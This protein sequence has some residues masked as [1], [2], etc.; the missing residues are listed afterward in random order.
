[1]EGYTTS[2]LKI[3]AICTVAVILIINGVTGAMARVS[4]VFVRMV[5]VVLILPRF[6]R[7][8][9]AATVLLSGLARLQSCSLLF[10]LQLCRDNKGLINIYIAELNVSCA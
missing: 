6:L 9:V 3:P 5:L 8:Q 4:L 2:L 10:S 7:V 1:M